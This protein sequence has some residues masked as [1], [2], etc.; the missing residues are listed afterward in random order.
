[1]GPG[2][3]RE[4]DRWFPARELVKKSETCGTMGPG[5]RRD[6]VTTTDYPHGD[7]KYPNAMDRFL[8]LPLSDRSKQKI[9]WDNTRRL[10]AL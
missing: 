3:R 7:S 4:D 2:L 6:L 10:Y 8:A 5:F 1:M 9:L